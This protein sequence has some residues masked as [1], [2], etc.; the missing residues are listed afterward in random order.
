LDDLLDLSAS[1]V[2]K[3]PSVS[4]CAT[5]GKPRF[6]ML[7]TI[8]EHALERLAATGELAAAR[9]R[10]ATYFLALAE[11]ALVHFG[12][13]ARALKGSGF[14]VGTIRGYGGSSDGSKLR[15]SILRTRS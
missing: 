1:L 2:R 15:H 10:H 11:Q 4:D 6:G 14:P 9:G 5:A 3:S 7:E 12:R 13:V 8:R